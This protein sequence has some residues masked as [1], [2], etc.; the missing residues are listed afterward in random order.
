MMLSE[1]SSAPETKRWIAP[2][3]SAMRDINWPVCAWVW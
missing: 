3:S 2:T 1:S